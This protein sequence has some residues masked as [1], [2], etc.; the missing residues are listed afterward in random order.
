MKNIQTKMIP[1]CITHPA[2]SPACKIII[3][4]VICHNKIDSSYTKFGDYC[5]GVNNI[6][7]GE[8]HQGD[9]LLVCG[10][11]VTDKYETEPQQKLHAAWN[12]IHPT[13]YIKKIS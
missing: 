11:W 12:E 10:R 3:I 4:E 13:R 2:G 9:S 6:L 8:P 1:K 5:K 7:Q